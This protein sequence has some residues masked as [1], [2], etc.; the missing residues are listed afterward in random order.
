M[1]KRSSV[2]CS[3][4]I[5]NPVIKE[6]FISKIKSIKGVYL[7]KAVVGNHKG[8][9][10]MRIINTTSRDYE[11]T[12]PTMV[13]KEFE[14]LT[15][16]PSMT[17]NAISKSKENRFDKIIE[18]LRFEHLNEEERKNVE[19]K[20]R[21]RRN[22]DRFHIP[23][24]T[25]EGIEIL[26]H[27]IITTDDIPINIKQYRYPPAH[28][29]EINHQIQELL[30]TD[31]VEPS[32][33]PYNS[34][35]WIVPKKPDSQGNKRWR[36]VTDY[37]KLNDKTI[38]D[39]YS[40]PNITE[41]LDQLESAKYFSKFDLASGFH[42]I[43]M[44]QENAHKT[45][46]ST[47]YGHFQ[48]KRMPF[49]LKNTPTT[50]QRLMNSVLSGLQGVKLFVYLNDIVIYSRSFHEHESKFNKLMERLRQARLRLQPDKCEFLQHE[51]S[52]LGHRRWYMLSVIELCCPRPE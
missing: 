52:Y 40:L 19:G 38:G 27:R 17:Y 14:N 13:I 44:A 7:G 15:S 30:D 12:T 4:N 42:Q 22:Q 43:Q 16:L 23:E 49:G 10:Y 34:A 50:F 35:L 1:P 24:D 29:E 3:T 31:V 2:P 37:R 48:F 41:I 9:G 5:A 21:I 47:P 39:A 6:G 28:R 18:L 32:I 20:R 33:S 8:R 45:A 51:V 46:F 26:E 25:L 36:L 11:F